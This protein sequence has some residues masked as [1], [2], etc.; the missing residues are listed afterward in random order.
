MEKVCVHAT[1]E[2]RVWCLVLQRPWRPNLGQPQYST[3][4]FLFNNEKNK[5]F[6]LIKA[7]IFDHL[8]SWEWNNASTLWTWALLRVSISIKLKSWKLKI[9]KTQNCTNNAERKRE[10][11]RCVEIHFFTNT[12]QTATWIYCLFYFEYNKKKAFCKHTNLMIR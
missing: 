9:N 5:R 2:R 11:K 4:T 7:I 10:K 12:F 3:E 6:N 8:L 1:N